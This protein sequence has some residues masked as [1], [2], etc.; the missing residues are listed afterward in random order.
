MKCKFC[1]NESPLINAHIIPAGFFRRIKDGQN[2]L[3]II[4]TTTGE[5]I[6]QS[7][8]GVYDQAIICRKCETIWQEWDNYVQ[9]LLAE[10]PLNGKALYHN[11]R[12]IGFVVD[13]FDYIKLKL[14]FISLLWR[15][16]VSRQSVFSGV[17]L[18]EFEDIAKQH[19]VNNNPGNRDDFSVV[20]SKFEHPL[21]KVMLSP[22]MYTILGVNYVRFYLA[23][24]RADIKVDHQPA[25]EPEQ[26]LND[27]MT[28]NKPLYIRC[29]EF[30]RSKELDEIKK[31]VLR[32]RDK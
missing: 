10:E 16:S 25:P 13:S 19:I 5:Y 8:I 2:P 18:G 27:V 23:S 12:K 31:A 9:Q 3:E 28:Q 11:N 30:E 17:S 21:A 26:F 22:F 29:L 14:F 6:K 1:G 15:A 32:I 4:P 24:Y 20:L 7:P